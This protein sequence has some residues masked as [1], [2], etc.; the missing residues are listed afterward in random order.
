MFQVLLI[1]V[2][3]LALTSPSNGLD[4]EKFLKENCD[5][6][7]SYRIT[8]SFVN[9][10]EKD[11]QEIQSKI[12]TISNA[13]RFEFQN[14]KVVANGAFFEKFPNAIEFSFKDSIVDLTEKTLRTVLS[15]SSSLRLI[16]INKVKLTLTRLN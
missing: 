1:A 4:S 14:S 11:G 15:K 12:F 5:L 3:F 9:L 2:P 16:G 7:S 8:C 10:Q 6:R 13:F